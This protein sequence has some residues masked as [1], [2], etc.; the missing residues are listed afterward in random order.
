MAAPVRG[1]RW[2]AVGFG[3]YV[4]PCLGDRIVGLFRE[5]FVSRSAIF[6]ASISVI[7]QGIFDAE[8]RIGKDP[9]CDKTT[10]LKLAQTLCKRFLRN[11]GGGAIVNT[12]SVAGHI[13]VSPSSIYVGT[14]H[15]VEGL[16]K[17][18]ALEF[19]KQGIR[20]NSVAPGGIDTDMIDRVAGKEG[21]RRNW[22]VS[23]HPVGRLRRE[24]RNRGCRPLP[25]FRRSE[26]YHRHDAIG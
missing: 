2:A 7:G 16:T 17:A 8:R 15:A 21:D 3:N 1:S 18:I 13:G 6:A 20:V 22:L 9:L 5:G 11:A 4:T 24:R 12:S 10:A 25:C 23:L 26:I 14:K 19:A